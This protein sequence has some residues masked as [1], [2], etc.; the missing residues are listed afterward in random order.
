[1]FWVEFPGSYRVIPPGLSIR[2]PRLATLNTQLSQRPHK[3]E[4]LDRLGYREF[5][6]IQCFDFRVDNI[7]QV[8]F[9]R[10]ETVNVQVHSLRC[11]S[12]VCARNLYQQLNYMLDRYGG[13]YLD[14]DINNFVAL[15]L[16]RAQLKYKSEIEKKRTLFSFSILK[17]ICECFRQFS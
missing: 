10:P 14:L 4:S 8:P 16:Y 3:V 2:L 17:Y 5:F 9:F 15:H 12:P 13:T 11:F 6:R 7:P 1:M